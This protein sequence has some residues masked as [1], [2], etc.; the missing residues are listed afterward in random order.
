MVEDH[1]RSVQS[2]E[3]IQHVSYYYHLV[4]IEYHISFSH[5]YHL[6]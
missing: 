5:Y 2:T 4:K 3:Y 6:V 1:G